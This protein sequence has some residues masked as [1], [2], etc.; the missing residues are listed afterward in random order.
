MKDIEEY[1]YDFRE[2]PML[3]GSWE[4]TATAP[5]GDVYLVLFGGVN[6]KARA[7]EYL[8]WKGEWDQCQ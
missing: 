1:K 5:N 6:A 3:P 4:V 7:Q 8:T 2:H